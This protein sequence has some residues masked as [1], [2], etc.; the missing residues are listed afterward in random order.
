MY[1][2]AKFKLLYNNFKV[3]GSLCTLLLS[4][5]WK[6]NR[7]EIPCPISFLQKRLKNWKKAKNPSKSDFGGTKK[8]KNM[9]Y[10]NHFQ[11]RAL[12]ITLCM[13]GEGQPSHR[14]LKTGVPELFRD[15]AQEIVSEWLCYS[16]LEHILHK[17]V[18]LHLTL[19][20]IFITVEKVLWVLKS[21]T[22]D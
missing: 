7:L 4:Q 21:V 14:D 19:G 13:R 2:E 15:F 6:K 1:I 20:Q 16:K 3:Y 11:I 12:V 22:L 17:T 8:R 9:F 5:N 10:V 18:S